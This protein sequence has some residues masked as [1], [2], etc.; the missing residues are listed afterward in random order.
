MAPLQPAR[1]HPP[2]ALPALTAT[3]PLL[4]LCSSAATMA[5][6]WSLVLRPKPLLEEPSCFLPATVSLCLSHHDGIRASPTNPSKKWPEVPQGPGPQSENCPAPTVPQLGGLQ[7]EAGAHTHLFSL[8]AVWNWLYRVLVLRRAAWR[9]L[10]AVE[11]LL[12][13]LSRLRLRVE[14]TGPSCRYTPSER[15][16]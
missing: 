15:R 13:S 8:S 1:P 5:W 11:L 12:W 10:E 14:P 3:P 9:E 16:W 4:S 2:G 7:A 6:L